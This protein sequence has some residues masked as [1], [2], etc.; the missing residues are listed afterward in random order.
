MRAIAIVPRPGHELGPEVQ[1]SIKCLRNAGINVRDTAIA[2]AFALIWVDD[3][4][5]V[6]AV[7]TL[8]NSGYPATALTETDV[9]H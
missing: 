1:G 8:R 3:A 6:L 4:N 5:L 7:E 2:R 9:P